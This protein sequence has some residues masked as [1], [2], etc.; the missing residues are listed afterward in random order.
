[1]LETFLIRKPSFL[2]RYDL[3]TY[4]AGDNAGIDWVRTVW[5]N[6]VLGF[7]EAYERYRSHSG[8]A[9]RHVGILLKETL[10]PE[11]ASS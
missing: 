5:L 11:C 10:W 9:S 1:M 3:K 4:C 7:G 2:T 8:T 6:H